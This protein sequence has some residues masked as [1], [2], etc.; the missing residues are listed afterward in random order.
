MIT[1]KFFGGNGKC[2]VLSLNHISS[3]LFPCMG[4]V[5]RLGDPGLPWGRGKVTQLSP[6]SLSPAPRAAAAGKGPGFMG[7]QWCQPAAGE[8]GLS[9]LAWLGLVPEKWPL[10]LRVPF[11]LGKGLRDQGRVE[12][13]FPQHSWWT[14]VCMESQNLSARAHSG[15]MELNRPHYKDKKKKRLQRGWNLPL[16]HTVNQCQNPGS[17]WFIKSTIKWWFMQSFINMPRSCCFDKVSVWHIRLSSWPTWS[18]EWDEQDLR[19]EYLQD[20]GDLWVPARL[21]SFKPIFTVM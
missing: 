12:R 10:H 5:S 3:P 8:A 18:L 9:S 17:L 4:W 7:E 20:R 14:A 6:L 11:H 19:Y 2:Q 21:H 16:G 1:L 13:E 15:P